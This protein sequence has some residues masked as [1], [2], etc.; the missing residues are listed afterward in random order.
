VTEHERVAVHAWNLHVDM[1]V[2]LGANIA[3][4]KPNE[5]LKESYDHMDQSGFM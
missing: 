3:K 5:T 2:I 1:V 4:S